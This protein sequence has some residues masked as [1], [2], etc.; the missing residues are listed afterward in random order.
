ML[1]GSEALSITLVRL[2]STEMEANT[3][4]LSIIIPPHGNDDS[5]TPTMLSRAKKQ[6]L[7]NKMN[8]AVS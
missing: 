2:R 3:H 7:Q 5:D 1:K 4:Q 6:V 8:S